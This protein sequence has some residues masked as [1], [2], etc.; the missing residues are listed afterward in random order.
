MA[1]A[2]DRPGYCLFLCL[3]QHDP[4]KFEAYRAAARSTL[5]PYEV[6]IVALH[7]ELE[8]VE[9]A[10]IHA[11]A[12]LAFKSIAQARS[13]YFSEAYQAIV[14][15]RTESGTYQAVLFEG[16]PPAIPGPSSS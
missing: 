5:T 15:Y 1:E 8:Q 10:A 3:G 2:A 13:W 6:E 16:H 4:Q 14:H 7:P 9:G 11:L 12:L